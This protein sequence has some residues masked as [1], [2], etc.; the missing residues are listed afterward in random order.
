VVV[1]GH[2]A[3][4]LKYLDQHTWLVISIRG[5]SL[6]LL[7]GDGCVSWDEDGHNFSCGFDSLRKSGNVE[8]KQVLDIFAA[9]T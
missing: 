6:L 5:E 1:L 8:Q 9:L 4:T 3:L 2:L 7:C